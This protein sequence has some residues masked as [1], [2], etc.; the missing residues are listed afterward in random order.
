[1]KKLFLM[2]AAVAA[3]A[4]VGCSKDDNKGD[5]L[6]GTTWKG[7]SRGYSDPVTLI[8]TFQSG[9]ILIENGE[10][11]DGGYTEQWT[12]QGS[13]TYTP[14]TVTVKFS[15]AK[16]DTIYTGTI[17]GNQMTAFDDYGDSY[18]FTKM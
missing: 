17:S 12:D 1:M 7:K 5:G 11:Q 10:Y 18:L 8:W 14:P 6:A 2:V 9:G 3:L 13:Y 4:C 16:G 15:D